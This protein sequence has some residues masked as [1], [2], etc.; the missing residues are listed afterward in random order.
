MILPSLTT[1]YSLTHRTGVLIACCF[2]AIPAF[3]QESLKPQADPGSQLDFK[4][5]VLPLFKKFCFDCH[6]G[7]DPEG[8]LQLDRLD[9][10]G[11]RKLH[12]AWQRVRDNLDSTLMPPDD[13]KQPSEEERK[14]LVA[15]LDA[16]PLHLDCSGAVHPGRVT[17]R[18]LNRVEYNNTIRDL[19]GVDLQPANDFPSDD[20]GYGFDNIGDVL[21]L[22]PLLLEKY[23]EAGDKV[24]RKAI[25]YYDA[26]HAPVKKRTGRTLGGS[27]DI[28]LEYEF[29]QTGEYLLKANASAD[30]AGPE[31]AKMTFRL[32]GQA[33]QEFEIKGQGREHAKVYEIKQTVEKG[34]HAFAVAFLNDYYNDK[35]PDPK[36]RGDRNL[37]VDLLEIIGPFGVK[38]EN[39]PESHKRI[40]FE[41]P[42]DKLSPE[43]CAKKIIKRFASKAYRRPASDTEVNRLF[44]IYKLTRDNGDPFERGIQVVVQAVL[45]SPH[46]L[47]RIEQ[48]P[49][50]SDPQ[51]IR[52]LN[53]YEL[54]S[55]LSY[56]IWS[57]MPD[58][59]LFALAHQGKL[60]E[61]LKPQLERMLKDAKSEAL[62]DNFAGQWLQLRSLERVSPNKRVFPEWTDELRH[63]MR[64]ETELFFSHIMREDRNVLE[65]LTADYSFLNE[66]LAKHYGVPDV[67][68]N[69]FRKVSLPGEQ[70]GGLLGQASILTVTSNP[71][72][73]SP[74]KRGKWILENLLAA[75]PPPAPPNVPTLDE[76]RAAAQNASLRT[77][78]EMHRSNPSCNA[79]HKV[80]D[81]LG[82]GLE[83][84]NAIGGWRTK[85]GK[86][87]ID[88]AGVMPT[89]EKI[90]GAKD[91]REIL[92][93]RETDFRRCLAEKLLTYALGRG[94]DLDDECTV[95][96]IANDAAQ[97]EN[98]FSAFLHGIVT[99]SQFQKRAA[100][101]N[102]DSK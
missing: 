40:I 42:S 8:K 27:G 28:T 66:R 56:F 91:L 38:I 24:A 10:A 9:H 49:E 17:V 81:P 51:R 59:E 46:F 72:R 18:R 73:T 47:F 87:D 71:A 3:A 33:L 43:E 23:L 84:Y 11:G 68:G 63:D 35:D 7:K 13:A 67:K 54:A 6:A 98:K 102:S 34:K 16:V 31:N 94:L 80:L 45:A 21:S 26:E 2:L 4:K 89:G 75:P 15:W 61:Q 5:E 88:P 29:P 78:L 19:C 85:D 74:V 14:K 53:E 1:V 58:S 69:E 97:H 50:P 76:G 95:R 100:S 12:A 83:N 90:T 93:K 20:I 101:R 86:F 82:F 22:Q 37:H 44:S 57:T 60:R 25:V 55:R 70:R 99:S 62:V 36:L 41:E 48:E 30:Q 92:S 65:F 52:T 64:Q 79:C 32:D 96:A 77:R 39:L